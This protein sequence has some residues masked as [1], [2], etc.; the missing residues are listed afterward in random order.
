VLSQVNDGPSFLHYKGPCEAEVDGKTMVCFLEGQQYT[1]YFYT[2]KAAF[3]SKKEEKR[4]HAFSC[5]L[6]IFAIRSF[7]P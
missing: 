5:S 1:V 2:R 6:K 7:C 4:A 3:L